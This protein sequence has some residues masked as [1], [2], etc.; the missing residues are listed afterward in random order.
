LAQIRLENISK[1]FP[2]GVEAVGNLSMVIPE[3]MVVSLLGPSGCGKTTTMRIIA[4]LET[5]TTGRV[6]FDERDVTELSAKERHVAMVFQFSAIYPNISVERNISLPLIAQKIKPTEIKKKIREVA[7]ILELEAF[8]EEIPLTLDA[9]T[10]QKVAIARTI[11][12]EP[13]V[14]LFDEPL[15]NVDPQM[16]VSLKSVIKRLS[17]ELGQ[18]FIYVT[19]DQSEAMTLADKI[20]VMKDGRLLQYDKPSNIYSYPINTFVAWFMGNPGMNFIQAQLVEERGHFSLSTASIN[21]LS[22]GF[23]KNHLL[24]ELKNDRRVILGIRPEDIK[25]SAEKK[26][27]NWMEGIC[28]MIEPMGGREI[29]YIRSDNVEIRAK[30]S[31]LGTNVEGRPIWFQFPPEKITLFNTETHQ[32]IKF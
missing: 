12:R 5:P 17:K 22:I 9:G 29:I 32:I 18:T 10:K 31:P 2:G 7:E 1:V 20:G 3:K 23:D 19:H 14:F 21:C 8:L 28:T 4:G 11:V 13:N 24:E 26:N 6:Y 16:R 27:S 30:I 25:V 15:N